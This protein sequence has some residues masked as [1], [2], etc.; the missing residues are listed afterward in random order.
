MRAEYKNFQEES[1]RSE[2]VP[3]HGHVFVV[4]D[5]GAVGTSLKQLLDSVGLHVLLFESATEFLHS[6]FPDTPCC[7]VLD[8]RLPVMSGLKL[9]EE[10][11]KAGTQLPIVFISGYGSISMAVRAMKSGAVDFLCKPFDTQELLDAVF[12]GLERDQQRRAHE[13]SLA[14]L[15]ACFNSLSAREREVFF[16]VTDGLLNKQIAAELGLSEIM[17]KVHRAN[18]L[19]KMSAKS[20]AALV[21]M[22]DL[23]REQDQD[24]KKGAGLVRPFESV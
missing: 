2:R 22:C 9:Q 23:L 13:N 18:V 5:N 7:L 3:S 17:V 21:R 15:R 14:V 8:V 24:L 12:A 10:L 11:A 20:V 1:I 19:R 4:D 16:R 6:A